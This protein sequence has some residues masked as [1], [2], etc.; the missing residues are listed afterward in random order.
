MQGRKKAKKAL[1]AKKD[2]ADIA[3]IVLEAD[4]VKLAAGKIQAGF[5]GLQG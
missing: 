4:D 2:A 1:K 5:R 3:D